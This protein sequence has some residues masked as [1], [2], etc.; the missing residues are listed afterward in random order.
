MKKSIILIVILFVCSH[1]LQAATADEPDS[2]YIFSYAN[3]KDAGRSGLHFAWSADGEKWYPIG[4][5]YAFVKSD[6]SRWGSE[7]RMLNPYLY[8]TSDD[9]WHCVWMLNEKGDFAHASSADLIYWGRQS[10]Y[11]ATEAKPQTFTGQRMSYQTIHINGKQ[12]SGVVR[13]VPR[14]VSTALI[15]AQ[16]LSAYR[17]KLYS[18]NTKDDA[19][20][21]AGLQPV[22]VLIKPD[23]SAGKKISDLLV[24]VFFEDINYAADG[25]LYAELVQNRDFEYS[26]DDRTEWNATT[27]WTVNGNKN[28]AIDTI[29]PIHP[30]N[31]HYAVLQNGDTLQ[32][33]G[34]DGIALK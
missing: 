1:L 27:A 8:R 12:Q 17:Q 5:G 31:R 21:F 34:F 11:P 23:I 14:S 20:R 32:N 10:Y 29:A 4:D 33:E 13:K 2:T 28:I 9:L 30:N 6:Y 22:E 24:G 16:Q 15:N 26:S 7:K 25:G 18:E 3:E 19:M